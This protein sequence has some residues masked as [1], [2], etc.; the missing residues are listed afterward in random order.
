MLADMQLVGMIPG[1]L[2]MFKSVEGTVELPPKIQIL[3]QGVGFNGGIQGRVQCLLKMGFANQRRPIAGLLEIVPHHGHLLGQFRTKRP[4]SM[5]TGIHSCD[6]G[7]P[8][9]SAGGVHCI[10][11][12]ETRAARRKPVEIRRFDLR[13]QESKSIPVL[14]ITGDEEN[15][16]SLNND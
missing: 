5:L 11:P 9:G 8:R 2:H 3:L 4:G 16:H 13:I 10:G 12:V 14:L 15:I 1:K 7:S 6:D